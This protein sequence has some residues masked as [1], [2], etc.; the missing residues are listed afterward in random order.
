[1]RGR[2]GIEGFGER[3]A[4]EHLVPTVC[5]TSDVVLL[6]LYDAGRTPRSGL[7][8]THRLLGARALLILRMVDQPQ[9]STIRRIATVKHAFRAGYRR[10]RDPC[11]QGNSRDERHDD[12][13]E[14][15]ARKRAEP[16]R[17]VRNVCVAHDI[18]FLLTTSLTLRQPTPSLCRNE[19]RADTTPRQSKNEISPER[20][21]GARRQPRP[22]CRRR[23][24]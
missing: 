19:C 3:R 21:Q 10:N 15:S 8:P 4:A 9:C 24:P 7:R 6:H 14:L 20:P 23:T 17:M 11:S 12:D 1:M 22:P 2:F 5:C 16:T 13:R 18:S